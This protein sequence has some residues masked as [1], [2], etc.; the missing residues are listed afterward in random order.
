MESIPDLPLSMIFLTAHARGGGTATTE[1]EETLACMLAIGQQ[2]WPQLPLS[3]EEF[4]MDLAQRAPATPDTL[5]VLCAVD[6]YLV[7][8]CALGRH[9]ALLALETAYLRPQI[10]RMRLSP[11]QGD[12]LLQQLRAHL[13][14][15]EPPRISQYNGKGKLHNFLRTIATRL[16]QSARRSMDAHVEEYGV[17]DLSEALRAGGDLEVE[18]Q[19]RLLQEE[20]DGALSA[21]V[22]QLTD[23]QR[24]DLRMHY[25]KHLTERRLAELNQIS[26]ATMH[27][28]IV[29]ATQVLSRGVRRIIAERLHMTETGLDSLVRLLRSQLH[30]SLSRLL[31][32]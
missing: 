31:P 8:G 18:Y 21:M 13:L 26:Q 12:E 24:F 14:T 22:A 27:R 4:L 10:Q 1:L 20:I 17:R 30:L 6:L 25:V 7:S 3:S 16:R 5:K 11:A 15:G 2:A 32:A 9:Q 29:S 28:R 23:E 19:G